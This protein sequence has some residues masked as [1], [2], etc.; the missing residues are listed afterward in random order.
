MAFFAEQSP[1]TPPPGR[2]R[3]EKI[4]K[5]EKA[6][7]SQATE[8]QREIQWLRAQNVRVR[9]E[10]DALRAQ[11]FGPAAWHYGAEQQQQAPARRTNAA[12]AAS[13]NSIMESMAAGAHRPG[14][15][16]LPLTQLALTSSILP[17]AMQTFANN[18]A[19]D[20]APQQQRAQGGAQF[21]EAALT[22]PAAG[23]AVAA[24]GASS[25]A[26]T[27]QPGNGDAASRRASAERPK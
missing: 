11:L 24:S 1:L 21:G 8:Q 27:Q 25:R 10:N 17:G 18:F 12:L 19:P 20:A 23:P 4:A 7:S 26:G 9:Q 2:R 14:A 13:A 22:I 5:L 16:M 6:Q 3:K 15:D